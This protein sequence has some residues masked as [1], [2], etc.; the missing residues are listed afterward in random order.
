MANN[1]GFMFK[2]IIL[3][4]CGAVIAFFPGVITWVFY[5]VGIII[6]IGSIVTLIK[7]FGEGSPMIGGCIL[8]MLIG[9]GIT[10]LPVLISVKIPLIAGIIFTILGITRLSKTLGKNYEGKN[11][12]VSI[13][14]AVLL[15]IAGL[16][17]VINPLKISN[18]IRIIL[19]LIL[20]AFSAFSFY[21]AYTA[22]KRYSGRNSFNSDIIDVN[23][24][25]VHDKK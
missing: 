4:L 14:L 8:G 21:T 12:A 19:G 7:S 22:K 6:I 16:F 11:K 20:I 9:G 10:Y 15:I 1:S 3:A 13:A 23:S 2:G 24:F 17:F 18:V 25:S 5:A